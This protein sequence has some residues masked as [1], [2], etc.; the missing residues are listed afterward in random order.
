MKKY[1]AILFDLDGTLLPMDQEE[2]VKTYFGLLVKKVAPLGYEP[3]KLV[4]SIWKGTYA[5]VQ[6]NGHCNNYDRFW[7]VFGSIYG[8]EKLKDRPLFDEFY[9]QEFQMARAACGFDPLSKQ[10]VKKA[11]EL[12]PLILATN[13]I[14]PQVAT[15]SRI[16]WAGLD[17]DNF[18]FITTYEN[19]SYCKPNVEY[20]REIVEKMNLDPHQCLMI[21]NDVEEDMVSANLG[22][23][24]YLVTNCLIN[25]KN[26]DLSNYQKGSMND[27]LNL[28]Q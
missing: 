16:R 17:P 10:V 12:G 1:Q 9:R 19:S 15:Y 5:M 6:N 18:T 25:S 26:K 7:E 27:L 20:Y 8:Q 3:K 23:D 4:D 2:F 11:K 14:F 22:M 24:S 28:F 21:G 13:P